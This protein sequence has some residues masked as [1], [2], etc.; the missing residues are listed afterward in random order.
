MLP[1]FGMFKGLMVAMG[2]TLR[3]QSSS[4]SQCFAVSLE[5]AKFTPLMCDAAVR[6]LNDGAASDLRFVYVQPND[7]LV[8][9]GNVH[10]IP[11]VDV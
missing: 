3:N 6:Q 4:L 11:P 2:A 5:A 7:A 1:A 8:D 10:R 9:G